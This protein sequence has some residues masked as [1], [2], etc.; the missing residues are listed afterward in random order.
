MITSLIIDDEQH[1]IDRLQKLIERLSDKLHVAGVCR[2]VEEA[3]LAI[4]E[5]KPDL[6][7][8]DVHLQERTGFDILTQLNSIP[9]EIIFTT[10]F[11]Q[12]AVHAFKFCA[13]DYL[14][15]PIEEQDLREA[16]NK[17]DRKASEKE[18]SLK[19]DMLFHN[20]RN[21]EHSQHRI[22]IPNL[23]GF[24]F[25]SVN[26]IIRCQ[27][28]NNYTTIF[29]KDQQKLVAAKTLK[30]FEELLEDKNFFRVHNSHLVNMSYIRKY[31][32]GNGG[33]ITLQDGTEIEVSARR[34]DQFL[35][36][37]AQ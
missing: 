31:N 24:N 34:K 18:S 35:K 28:N 11:D 6:I 29:L 7:F 21:I 33:F 10:A 12:Y 22:C 26:D 9:F 15:K 37:V 27:S 20:L 5:V 25:V 14:L 16:I 2:N 17:I 4:D 8:L 1:C 32:K 19:I 36:R 23:N 13:L 30:D 3:L